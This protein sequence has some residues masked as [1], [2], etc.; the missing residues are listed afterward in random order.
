[1][2]N[3]PVECAKSQCSKRMNATCLLA[4]MLQKKTIAKSARSLIKN[5]LFVKVKQKGYGAANDV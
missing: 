4:Q 2:L 5:P 3:E 1:M